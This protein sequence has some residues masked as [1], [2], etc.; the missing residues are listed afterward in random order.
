LRFFTES[1]SD[2]IQ[3]ISM[4]LEIIGIT[5][6]YI[7]IR[8]KPL[9]NRIEAKILYEETRIRN[10][11]SRLNDNKLFVSLATIFFVFI[12]FL[13]IPYLVGFFDRIVPEKWTGTLMW[14]IRLTIPIIVFFVAGVGFILFGDFV[15]WLNRFS[16]GHAIGALGVV[17][18]FL[19][20]L[21]ETYQVITILMY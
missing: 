9:A 7:E 3:F 10:F 11:V 6:A 2:Y 18:T 14:V 21:G 20:L 1:A 16:N 5:L 12:F 19:G 13:D 4:F 17:V 8:Y 15:S